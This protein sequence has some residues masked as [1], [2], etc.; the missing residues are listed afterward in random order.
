MC[1]RSKVRSDAD[2]LLEKPSLPSSSL[3][4]SDSNRRIPGSFGSTQAAQGAVKLV[5]KNWRN[6]PRFPDAMNQM[7][8]FSSLSET[9]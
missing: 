1:L 7:S 9:G 3:T 8:T 5:S 4:K 6:E 2:Y